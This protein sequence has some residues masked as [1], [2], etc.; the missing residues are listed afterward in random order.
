VRVT[1]E[2]RLEVKLLGALK[3]DMDFLM[4]LDNLNGDWCV[5]NDSVANFLLSMFN[6]K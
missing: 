2:I 5:N 6:F 4:T 1:G 3:K